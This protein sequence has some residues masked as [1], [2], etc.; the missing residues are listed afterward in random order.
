M[1]PLM[2][3]VFYRLR[4]L[5]FFKQHIFC[6]PIYLSDN[7]VLYKSTG[8]NNIKVKANL[9]TSSNMFDFARLHWRCLRD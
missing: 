6:Q 9:S 4:D 5:S 2:E 7:E 1:H 3:K 8:F